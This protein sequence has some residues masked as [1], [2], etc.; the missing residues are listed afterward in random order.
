MVNFENFVFVSQNIETSEY[1][2]SVN[3][4]ELDLLE[5]RSVPEVPLLALRS[6]RERSS[7]FLV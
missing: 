6:S 5:I 3:G 4:A 1:I 2:V 7:C